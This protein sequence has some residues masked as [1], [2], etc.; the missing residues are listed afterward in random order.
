MT[1]ALLL[2]S[3]EGGIRYW[4]LCSEIICT[5]IRAH[6]IAL[7]NGI[8]ALLQLKFFWS[9]TARMTVV[10]IQRVYFFQQYQEHS[11]K[12]HSLHS[13]SAPLD[14]TA[15]C[16]FLP[17]CCPPSLLTPSPAAWRLA[18][19]ASDV[20][21]IICHNDSAATSSSTVHCPPDSERPCSGRGRRWRGTLPL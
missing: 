5:N 19:S 14:P 1:V 21:D 6:T 9:G 8:T 20:P 11:H 7:S 10:F 13:H 17:F 12:K 18:A 16:H 2:W 15:P 4:K 3:E